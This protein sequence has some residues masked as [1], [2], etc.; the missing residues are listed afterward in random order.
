MEKPDALTVV[1]GRSVEYHAVAPVAKPVRFQAPSVNPDF[2]PDHDSLVARFDQL[3]DALE[4]ASTRTAPIQRD[5]R[6]YLDVAQEIVKL[7][8]GQVLK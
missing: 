8:R 6:L 5:L 7:I 1:P 4:E 3:K 2:R